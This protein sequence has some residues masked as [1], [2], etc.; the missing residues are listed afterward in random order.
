MLVVLADA[1]IPMGDVN[2]N[3]GFV[4]SVLGNL[5]NWDVAQIANSLLAASSSKSASAA[6]GDP[7][8][9]SDGIQAIRLLRAE[10]ASGA[11]SQAAKFIPAI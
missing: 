3:T 11:N 1:V 7:F 8:A 9:I 6:L 5:L 2:A 10:S 4:G